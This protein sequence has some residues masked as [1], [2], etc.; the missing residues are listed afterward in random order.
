MQKVV[1]AEGWPEQY[2]KYVVEEDPQDFADRLEERAVKT[3]IDWKVRP[4]LASW[5]RTQWKEQNLT[6]AS[7]SCS[8]SLEQWKPLKITE[9]AQNTKTRFRCEDATRWR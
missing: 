8:P 4:P 6:D 9:A 1:Q 3:L 2:A 7:G 5:I